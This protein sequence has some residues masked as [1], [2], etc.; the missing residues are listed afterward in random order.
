MPVTPILSSNVITV[1][2]LCL[3]CIEVSGSSDVSSQQ[4][5]YYFVPSRN[6]IFHPTLLG[7]GSTKSSS[8]ASIK[9][10]PPA[11][12]IRAGFFVRDRYAY[13]L[14]VVIVVGGLSWLASIVSG[15]YNYPQQ[16]RTYFTHCLRSSS[17]FIIVVRALFDIRT[18][19]P[20]STPGLGH[21]ANPIHRSRNTSHPTST[22]VYRRSS[23]K[24]NSYL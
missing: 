13:L 20:T 4:N 2:R 22:R 14:R 21:P 3:Y 5:I 17:P 10:L 12:G 11:I 1:Q 6:S 15:G 8:L 18:Y 24:P 7:I 16:L 23:S 9:V 19:H